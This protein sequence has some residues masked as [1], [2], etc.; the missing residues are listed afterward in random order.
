MVFL[1]FLVLTVVVGVVAGIVWRFLEDWWE[2]RN[3]RK[4]EQVLAEEETPAPVTVNKNAN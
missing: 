3:A 1:S 2:K 4:V